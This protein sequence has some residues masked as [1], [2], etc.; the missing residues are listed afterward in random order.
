LINLPLPA[1]ENSNGQLKRGAELFGIDV[2][3]FANRMVAGRMPAGGDGR[4]EHA[5]NQADRKLNCVGCHT[6]IQRT[7]QSPAA[8]GAHNLSFVWAPIFSDVLIHKMPNIDAERIMSQVNTNDSPRPRDP[9]PVQRFN[10]DTETVFTTLDLPRGLADDVFSDQKASADGREF[11]T[12]PLMGLGRVGTPFLHDARVYLSTLTVNSNPAGTVTTNS[13]ETNAP[14]VVRTVDDAILA[15][16]EMHDLPAPDDAKTSRQV[17]GGCP[18]PPSGSNINY[19]TPAQAAAVI[20]P[21]YDSSTSQTNRSDA[22]EVIR[23]FRALS[24]A[25]QQALIEFLKQL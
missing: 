19:G 20:C 8:V 11:R 24:R 7:G 13:K 6:P 1:L 14:L 25:D 15:A 16:I 18:V 23:R 22:R 9:V 4:D 12:A 17:G 21:A 5:I 10:Q 3:A 2:I